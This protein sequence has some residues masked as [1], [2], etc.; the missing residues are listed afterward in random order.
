MS[1]ARYVPDRGD[2]LWLTFDPQAGHEQAGRRPALVLTPAS[3]NRKASLA[4][5]CPITSHTKGYPFEVVLPAGLPVSGVI[6]ADHLK[7]LDWV[8]RR[9]RFAVKATE[10]VLAEVTAKLRPLL[11]L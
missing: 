10:D 6:L 7:S 8:A 1:A 11:R 3:Y 9:A 4:L 2:L 5:M